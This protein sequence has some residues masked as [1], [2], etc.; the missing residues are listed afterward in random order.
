MTA[1]VPGTD[2]PSSVDTLE[3]LI[4][5][6]LSA[7]RTLH[8]NETY[9]EILPTQ[10]DSGLRYTVTTG[11]GNDTDGALRFLTRASIEI[12]DAALNDNTGK[13]WTY[14]LENGSSVLPSNYT[15]N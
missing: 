15:S 14:A 12:D 4:V 2:I 10:A 13:F 11:V 3:K 9:P 6:A 7:F 1:I 8:T 5:W